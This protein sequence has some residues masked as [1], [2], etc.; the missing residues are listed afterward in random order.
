MA[1]I[2]L[3]PKR[4]NG[5]SYEDYKKRQREGNASVKKHKREGV[6]RY[7]SKEKGM[8]V[9]PEVKKEDFIKK[10]SNE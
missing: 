9:K 5:E 3:N 6:M 7:P 1:E 8:F 10:G 4:M 2:N